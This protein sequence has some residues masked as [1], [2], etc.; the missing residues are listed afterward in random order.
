MLNALPRSYAVLE[1][2]QSST[3]SIDNL[4]PTGGSILWT[5]CNAAVPSG[6]VHLLSVDTD[7][8]LSGWEQHVV[9]YASCSQLAWQK[10]ALLKDSQPNARCT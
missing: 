1:C 6:E 10:G 8:I 5:A 9:V 7:C 3:S 4:N 2:C